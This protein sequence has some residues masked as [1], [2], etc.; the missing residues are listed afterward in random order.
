MHYPK[1]FRTSTSILVVMLLVLMVTCT[2]NSAPVLSLAPENLMLEEGFGTQTVD[3]SGAFTDADGDAI[4]LTIASSNTEVLTVSLSGTTLTLTEV[5][6]GTTTITVDAS[7]GNGGTASTS[8][9]VE[10][11]EAP[12]ENTPPEVVMLL[13]DLQLSE[14]FGSETVQLPPNF[15]D[16]ETPMLMFSAS[17]S[18]ESVVTVSVTG[19]TLTITEAGTG[20]SAVTVTATDGSMAS[21]SDEFD[22]VVNAVGNS[23]PTVANP[24]ADASYSTGFGTATID[25]SNVFTDPDGDA[26]TLTASLRDASVVTVEVQGTTLT[27]TEQGEGTADITV[28]ADDGNGNS[29]VDSFMVTVG[30]NNQPPRVANPIADISYTTGFASAT[31]DLSNVFADND[32]DE[33]TLSASSN[34]T[35]VAMAS[36]NGTTLTITEA[37]EGS[38][39]ITVTADDGNGGT[40]SDDFVVEIGTS[41]CANDNSIDTSSRKNCNLPVTTANEYSESVS[42]GVRTITTNRAPN[43]D[44]SENNP[45]ANGINTETVTYMVDA[46]PALANGVTNVVTQ[47]NRPRYRFGTALNGVPFDPAP[48][49]PFIFEVASTGEYNWDWVFEPNYNLGTV[50]LDCATAHVQP[51]GTYH[52]HGDPI[53]YAETVVAGITD[54]STTPTNPVHIGWAADGFPI[55]YLYGPD[56]GG[57]LGKLSSSYRIKSGNR[58][59][60]GDSEPCGEYNGKYTNDFEYVQ[61]LGDLDQCNGINQSITVNN[62]TFSYFYV[63][64]DTFPF[65]PRCISGTPDDSFRLGPG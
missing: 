33:L 62:E 21:V 40:V 64:T 54:G 25:L 28:T 29:G 11:T 3:L 61:G 12:V 37:G 47:E 1:S 65:V 26:L 45:T 23:A 2:P 51:D 22:V 41:Q 56:A 44:H 10:I 4:S 55:V 30:G 35:G 39:T 59:G 53:E 6:I 20:T 42:N 17:S 13:S 5:G 34:N 18:N 8:F 14:G 50:G 15:D 48:A 32:G 46:T 27:I 52:Y 31:V 63:I 43:H 9:L 57:S 19:G 24:I 7:D 58:P 36:V 49:E 60:D 38:A 16:A